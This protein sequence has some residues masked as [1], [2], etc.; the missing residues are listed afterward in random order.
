MFCQHFSFFL[1]FW[2][3]TVCG[4]LERLLKQMSHSRKGMVVRTTMEKNQKS[5]GITK[6]RQWGVVEQVRSKSR[7]FQLGKVQCRRRLL[8]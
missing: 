5:W 7:L 6:W 1:F 3:K 2:F 4:C 8:S